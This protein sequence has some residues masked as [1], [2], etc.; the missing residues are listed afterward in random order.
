MIGICFRKSC[1]D[2]KEREDETERAEDSFPEFDFLPQPDVQD[3]EYRV[4]NVTRDP[5]VRININGC[6]YRTLNV[7]IVQSIY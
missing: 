3:D 7:H 1:H 4:G 6:V 5:V 2:D